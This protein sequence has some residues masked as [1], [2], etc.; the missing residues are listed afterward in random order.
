MRKLL[1]FVMAA[2][3][4]LV[5]FLAGTIVGTVTGAQPPFLVGIAFAAA[6]VLLP[7]LFVTARHSRRNRPGSRNIKTAGDDG[8]PP[9]DR[10]IR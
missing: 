10:N 6:A 5:S 8:L 3:L 2:L 4:C 1:P 7:A 9:F